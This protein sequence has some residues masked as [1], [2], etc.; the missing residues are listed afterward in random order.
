[1]TL[2]AI[3]PPSEISRV[4]DLI[5]VLDPSCR[6]TT[7]SVCESSSRELSAMATGDRSRASGAQKASLR[8]HA[9]H[10]RVWPTAG[11]WPQSSAAR[12]LY[13]VIRPP[14]SVAYA[15]IGS[16][17][18]RRFWV[19]DLARFQSLMEL[20][21]VSWRST[22]SVVA[23]LNQCGQLCSSPGLRPGS[24]TCRRVFTVVPVAP[25]V[26]RVGDIPTLGVGAPTSGRPRLIR[27]PRPSA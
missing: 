20:V 15:A 4:W 27:R 6:S 9:P 2:H 3:A 16:C 12:S 14:P 13:A 10:H 8:R 5:G 1:M 19:N 21:Y 25:S 11:C 22:E 26:K 17:D 23:A 18:N 7:M 24:K